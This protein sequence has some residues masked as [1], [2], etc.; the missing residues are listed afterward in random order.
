[1]GNFCKHLSCNWNQLCKPSN[2]RCF[3]VD[4]SQC[5]KCLLNCFHQDNCRPF[6]WPERVLFLVLFSAKQKQKKK[7]ENYTY[8][9]TRSFAAAKFLGKSLVQLHYFELIALFKTSC[10]LFIARRKEKHER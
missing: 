2:R 9:T 1:M 3:F 7:E 6:A 4:K 10:K 5:G 8:F